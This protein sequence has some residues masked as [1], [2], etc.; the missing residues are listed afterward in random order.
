MLIPAC[1]AR[2][3]FHAWQFVATTLLAVT[4]ASWSFWPDEASAEPVISIA[5][6]LPTNIRINGRVMSNLAALVSVTEW[7]TASARTAGPLPAT[8]SRCSSTTSS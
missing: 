2:R 4:L 8:C 1:I 6:P 7:G 3:F 5:P